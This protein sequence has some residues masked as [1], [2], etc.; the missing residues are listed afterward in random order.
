MGAKR[1][2]R[3]PRSADLRRLGIFGGTFDPVHYGHLICAD[4]LSEALGL[5][6][7]VF[8]PCSRSPRKPGYRPAPARHRLE[9]VKLALGAVPGFTVS[10][11]ETRRGGASYTVDTV[12]QIRKIYGT[13]V[14][15]WLLMGMDAYLDVLSWKEPD[16]IFRECS[17]GVAC[18][19]GYRG[20]R[21]PGVA[22]GKTRFIEI[23]S[24]DISS[25]G[26]RHRLQQGRSVKFLVP[27]P[28]E[29][30]IRRYRLYGSGKTRGLRRR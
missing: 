6:L 12:R 29:A 16:A 3:R 30:Y 7:V 8:V 19:P 4:Q 11:I 13:Q 9:M 22:R 20:R 18:R 28:V 24:V 26:V 21:H 14:E 5:D 1:R 15:L 23:T 25:T 2:A 27:D 10:D 17:L